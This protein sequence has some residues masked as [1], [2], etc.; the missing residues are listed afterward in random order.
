MPNRFPW[1]RSERPRAGDAS[2]RSKNARLPHQPPT[3]SDRGSEEPATTKPQLFASNRLFN[4]EAL[5]MSAELEPVDN[6][7][8]STTP[9]QPHVLVALGL[10]LVGALAWLLLGVVDHSLW[11]RAERI[12]GAAVA[13]PGSAPVVRLR[14][15]VSPSDGEL[16]APGM[17]A[18]VFQG[19]SD[20]VF[21]E[22]SISRVTRDTS[23][24]ATPTTRRVL[25][26]D[27]SP[28]T[29]LVLEPSDTDSS[30]RLRV[31]IG[32]QAPVDLLL[33][34]VSRRTAV[35]EDG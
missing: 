3:A 17:T 5:K 26:I 27:V 18:Y 6:P 10:V 31:P 12:D 33:G 9:Y 34:L 22:G 30:Y 19:G 16:L 7:T 11:L 2:P 28:T 35:T 15:V 20:G 25:Q 23:H 13:P 24:Q 29:T 32:S 8:R 4:E 1:D 14:T 21:F